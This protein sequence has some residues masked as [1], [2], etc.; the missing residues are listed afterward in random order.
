MLQPQFCN[1]KCVPCIMRFTYN[2]DGTPYCGEII[3]IR[4]CKSFAASSKVALP[5]P[6]P[7]FPP[8]H[9]MKYSHTSNPRKQQ[10]SVAYNGQHGPVRCW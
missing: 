6:R 4:H 10:F 1:D 9:Q 8:V 7:L 3:W 5:P 2:D